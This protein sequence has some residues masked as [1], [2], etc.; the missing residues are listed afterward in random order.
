M[1]IVQVVHT[2]PPQIGGVERHVYEVC[3]Y[4]DGIGEEVIVHTT[5]EPGKK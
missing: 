3:K 5:G 2:F 1:K 4:L